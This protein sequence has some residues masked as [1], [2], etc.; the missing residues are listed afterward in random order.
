MTDRLPGSPRPNAEVLREYNEFNARS[1]ERLKPGLWPLLAPD[2]DTVFRWRVKF[3]CGCVQERLACTDSADGLLSGSD[4]DVLSWERLP[5]GQFLCGGQH[6]RAE[7]DPIRDV[8]DWGQR[9]E[10]EFPA[11]PAEPQYGFTPEEWALVRRD[12]PHSSAIWRTRLTCGHQC[13]VHTDL[14]WRPEDGPRY[15]PKERSRQLQ[16]EWRAEWP[17]ELPSSGMH[18][19][20]QVIL[21]GSPRPAPFRSCRLCSEVRS[22]VL[23]EP[24]GWLTSQQSK[25]VAPKH[26]RSRAAIESELKRAEAKAARLRAELESSS[27]DDT[28]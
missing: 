23:Y 12:K 25:A 4:F 15:L 27:Q 21:A 10:R 11:D 2:P 7:F 6:E 1:R 17:K 9:S 19:L 28:E 18:Y 22:V 20:Y 16:A 13:Q 8:Q 24:V 26:R 3:N 14:D 5:K